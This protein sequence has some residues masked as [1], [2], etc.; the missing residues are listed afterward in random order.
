MAYLHTSPIEYHGNLKSSNVLL[1]SRWTC[2]ISDFGLRELRIGEG[3]PIR[4]EPA[5]Y[6]G[7][8]PT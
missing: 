5:Y 7:K 8:Q 3:G 6:Y 1:D 2:K 4:G